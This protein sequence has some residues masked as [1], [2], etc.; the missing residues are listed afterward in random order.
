M[1][2]AVFT[3]NRSNPAYMAARLGADRA[4]ALFGDEVVHYVPDRPDDPD[5]QIALIDQALATAPDAIVLSPVHAS[6][7]DPAILR[8][9]AMGIPLFA[10]VNPVEAV[11][12]VGYVG[13]D[14][15][16]LAADVA[17]YLFGRMNG[18]GR[19][20]IVGGHVES[21]TSMA[22][23]SAFERV[24][25]ERPDIRVVGH[26]VG[27]YQR[28]VAREAVSRWLAEHCEAPDAFLVA[29][30]IMAVGVI[31]ALQAA[32]LRALVVG[33]NAI[34]EAIAAIREGRMLATADFNAMQMAFTVTECAARHLR[35][36]TVP[37]HVEL[38]VDLVDATNFQHWDRPYEARP[39]KT[40]SEILA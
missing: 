6:R 28:G 12:T 16:R 18:Q 14:D 25:R 19:V 26:C 5:Q 35:G 36:E 3:K 4:A 37:A 9:R 11:P 31:E 32:G 40:L 22:R 29:N 21:V 24:A 39:V 34:P 38:P 10:F 8:I 33:V 27:D 17:R 30:D 7:V 13:A 15:A 23:V 1:R 2:I 20:L